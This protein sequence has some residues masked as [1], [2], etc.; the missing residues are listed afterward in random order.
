MENIVG[1]TGVILKVNGMKTKSP[2]LGH[3]YG[4]MVELTKV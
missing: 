3:T 2:V 1:R 4:Q